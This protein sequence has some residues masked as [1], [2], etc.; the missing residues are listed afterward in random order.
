[1]AIKYG[2]PI[3]LREVARESAGAAP[4]LDLTVR[5]RRNRKSEWAR[6]M[7]RENV[8][9]T[10]NLI[11]PLFLIDGSNKREAVGSMPGVERLS[12]DQAVRE[13]ERAMKLTIPCIALFPYTE[14]SLRD[15]D[16]SEATN[17]NNLVCQAVRAIKKEFPD[18]GILCD[19]ALDPFTSH[20]HDGLIAD[21]RIL[22]DETVAVLVRQALVQA[23]AGCDIIAPSDMMDGRVGAIREGL[24]RSGLSD[25][26]IMAYAAKYASAFYGP[27][28][29]AIGS[30]KTLTGDKR[31]YQMDSANSDE[32]LREVELD[33]AEGADMVMVKPGMPYLDV[34]RRVKDTFA[35]PTFAYQVSGEYAMIAA[36]ANNGWLDGE[37]AM[38]ESLLAFKRA[39][40][41]GVLSYFA[42]KAAERLKALG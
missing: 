25:V 41:D 13:A 33:I 17:P 2:R 10:D 22:N 18:I 1:M 42:P 19:V 39:G 16:G 38:M 15:E 6:R 24:D 8:L 20:G 5:P 31:T 28:R 21:G 29:D 32:A 23:E 27:F 7:V 9:T 36:A 34:V 4:A 12:V 30:A 14:P 26:Q 35:M 40:A 11:W 37:R 3:E